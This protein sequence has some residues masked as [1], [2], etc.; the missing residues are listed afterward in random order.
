MTKV[1]NKNKSNIQPNKQ[2]AFGQVN[3]KCLNCES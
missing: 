3:T 1:P 2:E